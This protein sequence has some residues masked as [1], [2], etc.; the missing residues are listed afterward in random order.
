MD[1]VINGYEENA[2]KTGLR[3]LLEDPKILGIYSWSRGGGWYGPYICNELW[4]DLNAFVL[5]R[6]VRNPSRSEEEIFRQYAAE[7][8]GLNGED[9]ERFRE[10]CLLSARAILKGRYCEAFDRLLGESMLPCACW[11]RDDRLGG[12]DQLQIVLDTLA[13]HGQLDEALAEK[14][15]AVALWENIRALAGQIEWPAGGSGDFV[16]LSAEYGLLLFSIVH[17]GWRAL[18][19]DRRSNRNAQADAVALYDELW[20]RYRSLGELPGCPSLY[21]GEYFS[22]PGAPAVSGLDESVRKLTTHMPLNVG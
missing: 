3:D 2:V 4:P 5:A 14:A 18:I 10:L 13:A 1:G 8:L 12:A 17:Q 16:K 20:A 19:E 6:F 7:K 11:M 15:N 22:L 21:R 9:I